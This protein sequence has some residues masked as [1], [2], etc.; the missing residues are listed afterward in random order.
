VADRRVAEVVSLNNRLESHEKFTKVSLEK[1]WLNFGKL[2]ELDESIFE[3][4]FFIIGECLCDNLGHFWHEVLEHFGVLAFT[5]LKEVA[6]CFKS[7][8]LD[9]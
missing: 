8:K 9:V 7:L 6:Y 3:G 1:V 4:F 2:V 5:N